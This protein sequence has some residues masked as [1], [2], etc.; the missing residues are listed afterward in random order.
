MT[1]GLDSPA[2]SHCGPALLRAHLTSAPRHPGN[3]IPPAQLPRIRNKALI[4]HP[5]KC[6]PSLTSR[7]KL[8]GTNEVSPH[9]QA[10]ELPRCIHHGKV[11][12]AR[13]H[14]RLC[15]PRGIQSACKGAGR[16][17]G[18]RVLS[19]GTGLDP[20]GAWVN[21]LCSFQVARPLPCDGA[22]PRAGSSPH[23][24]R[25]SAHPWS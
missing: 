3:A 15:G 16:R 22:Q 11:T 8:R 10:C 9:E 4:V 7:R 17:G 2:Q 14:Q 18:R 23:P 19:F 5:Q 25:P 21:P 6:P 20:L 13:G 24:L 12:S 1:Q